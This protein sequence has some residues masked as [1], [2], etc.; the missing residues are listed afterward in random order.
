MSTNFYFESAKSKEETQEFNEELIEIA[1][2]YLDKLLELGC[3]ED[4]VQYLYSETL[5][6]LERE[7]KSIHIGKRSMGWKPL[8]Q[9]QEEYDSIHT[10][11]KWYESN[12]NK[13]RIVDEYDKYYSWEQLLEDLIYWNRNNDNAQSHLKYDGE[14]GNYYIKDGVEWTDGE[15]S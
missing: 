7:P 3:D 12:K 6:K 14:Y 10:M 13:W 2:E 4:N 11:K 9:S 8:F 5:W 15:F 1:K